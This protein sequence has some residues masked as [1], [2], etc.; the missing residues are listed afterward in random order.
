MFVCALAAQSTAT[1][2]AEFQSQLPLLINRDTLLSQHYLV[3]FF[4]EFQSQ[5]PHSLTNRDTL[6][7][8]RTICST[9]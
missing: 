9:I 4:A 2:I 5:L 6:L 1:P 3:F 8:H 7:A